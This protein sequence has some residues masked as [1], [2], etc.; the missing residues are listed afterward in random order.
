MKYLL[1]IALIFA[2]V[3]VK[4][5]HSLV[6]KSGDKLEGVVMGLE[7]DVLTIVVDRKPREIPLIEVSSIF[8]NEYVPYDGSFNPAEEEKSIK[9]RDY[10]IKYQM[11]DRVM[12]TAPV[13]SN[14]TE[15]KG[16]VVVD[17]TIDRYGVV[18]SVK[19]GAPGSTTSNEY[20]Y[21]KAEFAAKSSRFNEH[22]LGPTETKGTIII[23]Y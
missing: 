10:V 17:V 11:K 2:F 1:S 4:S 22:K 15:H 20:L 12:E 21:V 16:R 7:N 8:F 18:K 5:Q 19:A 14:G 9:S 23:D 6:L 3:A 13:I